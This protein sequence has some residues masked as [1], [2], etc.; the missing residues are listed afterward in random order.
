MKN[1]N[2][3]LNPNWV[4]GFVDGEGCFSLQVFRSKNHI[5][6][7]CKPGFSIK[8]NK[9]DLN[10]LLNIKSF[11]CDIGNIHESPNDSC[12]IYR[13]H[14]LE[15][16]LGI[17]V[18]HFDRYLLL[19][20]KQND[21]YIWKNL[22]YLM[23]A[24]NHLTL[25][26]FMEILTWKASLNKGLS[27]NL[28]LIFPNIIHKKRN[29]NSPITYIDPYWFAGFFS[30][31][32]CFYVKYS[33]HPYFN[34]RLN[35]SVGQL[36]KDKILI[37]SFVSFLDCGQCKIILQKDFIEFYVSN[38]KDIYYKVI[39]FF[40]KYPIIGN[41]SLDFED[42]CKVAELIKDQ[43]HLTD[44]GKEKIKAIKLGMNQGRHSF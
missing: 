7:G 1:N 8:L 5:K 19:T 28:K 16:L 6:W 13:V 9:K 11:F 42:F 34:V 23:K 10:V 27:E 40:K 44:S 36:I 18:P 29:L 14:K 25:E 30:G 38:Y 24:K 22:L 37:N 35:I 21:F 32:G 26:G 4:T 15:D 20:D 12:V 39:P 33:K 17:I 43:E 31:E 2:K 41:K 3:K